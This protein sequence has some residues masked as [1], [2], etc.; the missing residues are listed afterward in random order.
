MFK[1]VCYLL[2]QVHDIWFIFKYDGINTIHKYVDGYCWITTCFMIDLSLRYIYAYIIGF[3]YFKYSYILRY[4][5]YIVLIRYVFYTDIT[6]IHY[7]C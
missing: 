1:N 3:L 7:S 5:I 6:I 2:R 4:S